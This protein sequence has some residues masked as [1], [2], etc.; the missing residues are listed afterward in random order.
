MASPALAE[1]VF[2]SCHDA[3]I[4]YEDGEE[5]TEKLMEMCSWLISFRTSGVLTDAQISALSEQLGVDVDVP[6][7]PDTYESV[8]AAVQQDISDIFDGIAELGEIV[9]EIIEPE[10][11]EE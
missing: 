8:I 1:F 6:D 3:I 4:K 5:D 10:G 9:S 2:K 7:A 11:G